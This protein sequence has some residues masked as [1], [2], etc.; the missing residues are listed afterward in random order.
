MRNPLVVVDREHVP[1]RLKPQFSMDELRRLV[2]KAGDHYHS[3]LCVLLYTGTRIDEAAHLRW[4]DVDCSGNMVAVTLDSGAN[5]KRDKERLIALQPELAAYLLA[6]RPEHAA[7]PIF[8]RVGAHRGARFA[9]YLKRC[10]VTKGRRTPH[11]LR[12]CYAGLQ[13]AAGLSHALLR[14][15]MGHSADSTTAS[16]AKMATSYVSAVEGWPRGQFQLMQGAASAWPR[17]APTD[18][19]V[20]RPPLAP[21]PAVG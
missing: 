8:G 10:G 18:P 4:E 5:I 12:H 7:G 15:Y 14:A 3:F 6:I 9:A 1:S 13:T 16:Y 2:S 17:V 11:S 20:G 21:A 19:R